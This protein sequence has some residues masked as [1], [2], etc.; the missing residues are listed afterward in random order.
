MKDKTL[1]KRQIVN[2]LRLIDK[3]LNDANL[4][5]GPL[6]KPL[7]WLMAEQ[8]PEK[9]SIKRQ[10]RW[11]VERCRAMLKACRKLE[12]KRDGRIPGSV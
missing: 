7:F 12:K 11:T 4:D 10:I 2:V 5:A 9:Y 6:L 1:T 8:A 3:A